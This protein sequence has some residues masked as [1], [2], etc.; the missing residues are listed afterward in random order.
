MWIFIAFMVS[1]VR[2]R[3]AEVGTAVAMIVA[4]AVVLI[5]YGI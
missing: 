4:T 3:A 1:G 5:L 2:G